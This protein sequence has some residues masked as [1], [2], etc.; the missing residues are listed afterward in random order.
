MKKILKLKIGDGSANEKYRKIQMLCYLL[1]SAIGFTALILP[2]NAGIS[3][4]IFVI[5]QAVFLYFIAPKRKPL[6]MLLPIFILALNSFISA[7][8]MWHISNFFVALILYSVMTL[9]M[10]DRLPLKEVSIRFITNILEN[11][12][13]PLHHMGAPFRWFKD[14]NKG[15]AE[16]TRRVILGI[17]ISIP[18]LLFL[19][20]MLSAADEVFSHGSARVFTDFM[21]SIN[22]TFIFK[23]IVGFTAGF[24]LF[25][26]IYSTYK[27]KDDKKVEVKTKNGDLII[28]NILLT[29]ILFIYTIFVI[30]QFRYL[31]AD[32]NNLPYG[33]SYTYYARHGFFELLFLSFVNI[34]L[35]LITVWLTKTKSG[36]GVKFTK[37]LCYYLC[38]VTVILL[39]SSFYRMWLY[40]IDDGLTRLRL[41]VFGFLFFEAIGL[42]I[43]FF[44]IYKPKFN[45][46]AVYLIIGLTYYLVLNLV[47]IDRIIAKEQIDRY[48]RTGEGGVTY[49]LTLSD[50]AAPEIARLLNSNDEAIKANANQYFQDNSQWYRD[51]IKSWQ[52]WNWSRYANL[53]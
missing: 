21:L 50:D 35:I 37:I 10:M 30:I 40:N 33:L 34:M 23:I 4:P 11:I 18:C 9:W 46:I 19:I 29:S 15:N 12:F 28:L 3:V 13:E 2:N 52:A 25:G 24:Y 47:P 36:S 39:I 43:T 17:V 1:V 44:Y 31:F 45:I 41:L 6:L 38:A 49:S 14:R 7:N 8:D 32:G 16:T 48:F 5:I 26:F 53:R 42:I 22:F 27:P 20:L 51:N